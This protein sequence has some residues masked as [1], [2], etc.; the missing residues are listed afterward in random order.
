MPGN[1]KSKRRRWALVALALLLA[2]AT[3]G[4][5]LAL[6]TPAGRVAANVVEYRARVLWGQWFGNGDSRSTG[7]G[8][9]SGVTRDSEGQPLADTLVLVSTVK[10]VVYQATS[11]EQGAYRI[12]G[13]PAGRYVPVASKWGYDDAL[14]RRDTEERT[15]IAVRA[16][17]VKVGVDLHL[18]ERQPWRPTLDEPA[19][20]GA[21]E[22]GYALFPAEVAAQRVPVTYTNEGLVITTTLVY[23]PLEIEVG[24][25]LPVV[26]ASYPSEPL[27]WDRVSVALANEGYVVIASGPSPQRGLD[28]YGMARDLVQ[29]VAYLRD[30][31]LSAYADPD[32]QGWLGGSFSSLIL[33]RALWEESEDVDALVWVGGICDGFLWVQALYDVGLEI[34]DL[35][36]NYVASLGRP[37]RTPEIYM[38]YSPAF[39]AVQMPPALVVHTTADEVVPYNQSVR[40]AEALDAANVP[41]ELFLYEDTTHYLDQVNVTPET[42]ELYSRLAAFLDRYVRGQ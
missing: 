35:Y 42:A 6:R 34:P 30:G 10:G 15:A 21:P 27:N 8:A 17:Q 2:G 12:E 26:V 5:R 25:S 40:F 11:D 38:G 41:H 29:A 33:Y 28:I 1:R 24:T 18:S 7:R 13:V 9:I 14:Y 16:G 39:H 22:T 19:L 3:L 36:A 31:Q 23:E 20:L 4:V 32:R 37:D